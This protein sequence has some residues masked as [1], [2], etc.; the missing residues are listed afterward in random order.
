MFPKQA[1]NNLS[2]TPKF[3]LTFSVLDLSNIPL[4]VGQVYVKWH[5]PSSSTAEHRG[6]TDKARITDHKSHF[7]YSKTVQIRLTISRTQALE[8]CDIHFEILQ[9]YHGAKGGRIHLG[10]VKLNLAEYTAVSD[11]V[12]DEPADGQ[13]GMITRR[14]LMQDSKVN[15]TLKIG[16]AMKQIDGDTNFIPPPLKSAMVIGGLA[17]I[18]NAEED[19]TTDMPS[20]ASKSRELSEAQDIYR[21]TLAATWACERGEMPPDKLIED[22]FAGGSGGAQHGMGP[23]A[24]KSNNRLWKAFSTDRDESSNSSSNEDRR[25]SNG[26]LLSPDSARHSHRRGAS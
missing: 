6:R 24:F 13:D 17:G 19:G 26:S 5:L 15:A 14:Y 2:L 3:H 1:L 22:I 20:A 23:P 7:G 11:G 10:N 4:V 8:P 9:E 25:T 21:R 12:V 18:V 16:I